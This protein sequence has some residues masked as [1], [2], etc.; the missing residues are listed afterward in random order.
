MEQ[1]KVTIY[2]TSTCLNCMKVKKYFNDNNVE[3]KNVDLGENPD[4]IKEMIE[5]SGQMGVPVIDIDGEFI[6]GFQP[7]KFKSLL[8]L[9]LTTDL[10]VLIA[11]G[12]IIV[13]VRTVAEYEEG[14]I[15]DSLNIP[16]DEVESR[17]SEL[18]KDK[19]IITCC[20]SGARS[21]AAKQIL[22]VSGFREVYNGGSCN[23][24]K[25][26]KGGEV[27]PVK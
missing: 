19:P 2:S 27:C 12:A 25:E 17:M 20:E 21:A 15:K 9:G 4:A 10:D 6:V 8:G 22:G 3:F 23:N 18:N 13:D 1:H 26:S 11:N 5:K 7:G 16:L 14:H 24:L